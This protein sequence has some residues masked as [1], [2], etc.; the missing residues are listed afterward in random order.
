MTLIN[1]IVFMILLDGRKIYQKILEDL[2][3]QILSFHG[4]RS[5]TIKKEGKKV[6]LAA[7]LVGDNPASLIYVQAKKTA[8][9]KVGI[10]FFYHHLSQKTPQKAVLDLI[11]KL[12][13]DP[14]IAGI[15]VQLPLPRRLNQGQILEKISAQKDIDGFGY[16]L[17]KRYQF[18]PPTPWGILRLLNEYKIG[19]KNKMVVIVG[20][21]FLV[22]KP[23]SKMIKEEGGLVIMVNKK[24]KNL[25]E[26]TQSADILVAAAGV[27][28]LIKKNMVKEGTVVVDV[29][30]NRVKQKVVGDVDFEQ[31]SKV[32]AAITPVPGGV[33]P[34]TVAIL[35]ENVVKAAGLN[36]VS[37]VK[38][39]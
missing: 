20:S 8:C 24:T 31:V 37:S 16:I 18:L 14:Q 29:G 39:L 15:L 9:E 13:L 10:Q 22:G 25:K 36:K 3:L 26:F 30:N 7:I 27:P 2:R 35:L 21:G 33:G 19:L 23:L 12:N 34:M 6:A 1:H 17:G 28:R 11:D 38:N 32:A 5:R 4:E